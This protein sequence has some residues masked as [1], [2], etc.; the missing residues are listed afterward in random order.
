MPLAA[1]GQKAIAVIAAIRPYFVVVVGCLKRR[2]ASWA[3]QR[4]THWR[5]F[6]QLT[7]LF[8]A[9]DMGISNIWTWSVLS[10]T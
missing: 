1:K 9:L 5:I 3:C 10:R 8:N 6:T 7:A 4:V 2:I